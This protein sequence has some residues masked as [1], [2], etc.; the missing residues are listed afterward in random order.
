MKNVHRFHP[1]AIILHWVMAV[2][3]ILMLAS[4]LAME[5]LELEKAL[6]FQLFQWHKSLGVLLMVAFFLRVAVRLFAAH[7]KLPE[8]MPVLE[9]K[10]AHAGHMMLYLWMLALPLSGWVMVS[11]SSFGLP[12]IVFGWFEWPHIPGIAGDKGLR[13]NANLA[14]Q[15]LAYSFIALIAGHIAAAVKHLV[16]DHENLLPRMGVGRVKKESSV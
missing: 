1:L 11:A 10:A 12:T 16:I 13:E 8:T 9:R 7:P 4:G 15:W 3:F 5:Y 6:V 14:H 2:S